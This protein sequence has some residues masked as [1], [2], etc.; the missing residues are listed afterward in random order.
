MATLNTGK[1][2]AL[3]LGLCTSLYANAAAINLTTPGSE[4]GGGQYTLGFEFTVSSNRTITS[5][6]VYDSGANGL[7]SNAQIGIWDTS[8]NLLTSTT[9]LAGTGQ[10]DGL[11]RYVNIS[12]F[13]LVAGTHYVIGA[14]T[15]DLASSL[16]TLQGGSGS[17]DPDVDVIVD[18]YS[19]FNSIFSFPTQTD[20]HADGAWLGANF[21]TGATGSVPE[22][23]SLALIALGLLGI[24]VA[25]QRKS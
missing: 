7:S 21:R 1:A 17:I 15:T 8:G 20:G 11:F 19:A 22:P 3:A 25:R 18:R 6:G 4:Y 13:S 10:L 23:A 5:L 9:I 2:L 14:Y 12:G 16:N 24:G